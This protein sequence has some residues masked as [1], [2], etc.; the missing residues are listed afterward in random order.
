MLLWFLKNF[1][2]LYPYSNPHSDH[3]EHQ[4][5][6]PQTRCT[7]VEDESV[8][9]RSQNGAQVGDLCLINKNLVVI[10]LVY[11]NISS[12]FAKSAVSPL[13]LLMQI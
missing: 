10:L 2:L 11:T 1:L 4:E 6:H 3:R 5:D 13:Y 12:D 9:G 7:I 8:A